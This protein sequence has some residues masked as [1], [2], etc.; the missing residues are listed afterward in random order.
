MYSDELTYPDFQHPFIVHYAGS[1]KC[2]MDLIMKPSPV[3][4]SQVDVLPAELS[5]V[6]V[7]PATPTT[8]QTHT[9]QSSSVWSWMD[10]TNA[11]NMD[12]QLAIDFD[13]LH[14]S[15]TLET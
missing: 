9:S 5:P 7:M 11:L 15:S 1:K 6:E 13:N 2:L 14:M 10:E 3:E 12:F 8:V 4:T